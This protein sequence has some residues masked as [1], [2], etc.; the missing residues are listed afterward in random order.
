[1]TRRGVGSP[2]TDT[3][4]RE[5]TT[6]A[7]PSAEGG[8]RVPLRIARRAPCAASAGARQSDEA[9]GATST[10]PP[11]AAAASA[12]RQRVPSDR[13]RVGEVHEIAASELSARRG[14]PAPATNLA[15]DQA[16]SCQA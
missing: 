11:A 10:W 15:D 16:P 6:A 13:Q 5:R 12:D 1:M 9:L 3:T 7:P 8:P 14:P 4:T 2:G